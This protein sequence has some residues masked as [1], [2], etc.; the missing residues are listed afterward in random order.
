MNS[1]MFIALILS[2]LIS[3]TEA[4]FDAKKKNPEHWFSATVRVIGACVIS[5]LLIAQTL[6]QILF[7]VMLLNVYWIVFDPIYALFKTG[8]WTYI[9]STAKTDKIAKKIFKNGSAYLYGKIWLLSI[10]FVIFHL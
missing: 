9:G 4:Y 7:A 3:C 6:Y 5:Y 8:D 10:L 2:A 1:L